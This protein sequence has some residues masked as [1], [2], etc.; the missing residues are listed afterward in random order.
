[1]G[2]KIFIFLI[3]TFISV[4][5]TEMVLVSKGRLPDIGKGIITVE[6][7]FYIAKYEVTQ[8]DYIVLMGNN[9]SKNI[10]DN[11]PVENVTWYDAIA[12]CNKLSEKEGLY[13]YYKIKE[14]VT[15]FKI[16][17]DVTE[18]GGNGYRLPS[19][20]EWEYAARGG[21]MSKGYKYSGSN[22]LDDVAWYVKN[23]G[24]NILF[25]ENVDDFDKPLVMEKNNI[26]T[27]EIGTKL[28]NELGIYDMSGN[29]WEWSSTKVGMGNGNWYYN[30]H[31]GSFADSDYGGKT[32]FLT[33]MF[34]ERFNIFTGFRVLR[35]K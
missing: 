26:R 22:V 16:F 6:N 19:S 10:N 14:T 25:L 28:P 3:M 7:D 8:K 13:P 21:L 27:H 12:Y 2:L 9:P 4:A 32:N 29:V 35:E 17:I 11:N 15:P 23:S 31:G 5:K 24:D 20:I 30:I 1:M 33:P 18:L 34:S